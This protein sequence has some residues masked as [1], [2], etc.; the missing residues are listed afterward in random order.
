[1]YEFSITYRTINIQILPISLLNVG[2][3]TSIRLKFVSEKREMQWSEVWLFA[4]NPYA[5]SRLNL[6][7]S[8]KIQ[9][10]VHQLPERN[11]NIPWPGHELINR[12]LESGLCW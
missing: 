1:M 4:S 3:T 6:H 2:L 8:R 7:K 9:Q 10:P 11:A 12:D 5:T